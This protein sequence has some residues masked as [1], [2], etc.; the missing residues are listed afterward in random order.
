[1]DVMNRT[2]NGARTWAWTALTLAVSSVGCQGGGAT[3]PPSSAATAAAP[4]PAE[5]EPVFLNGVEESNF[6]LTWQPVPLAAGA[7]AGQGE[8]VLIA[9]A[10]FKCNQ[11]YPYKLKLTGGGAVPTKAE[12]AKPDIVV[13]KDRVVVPVSFEVSGPEASMLGMFAFSVCTDDKCLIE[14]KTLKLTVDSGAPAPS[15]PTAVS[16]AATGA[17]VTVGGSTTP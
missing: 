13:A 3:E 5:S 12:I 1:M 8:L 10:P 4:A 16:S 2:M 17:V 7:K 15:S 14:R 6:K 9:K 11:D